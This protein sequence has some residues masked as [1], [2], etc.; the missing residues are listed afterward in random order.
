MEVIYTKVCGSQIAIFLL[1]ITI[2]Q[3]YSRWF[4]HK[5][6]LLVYLGMQVH[7]HNCVFIA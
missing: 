1:F 3:K 4:W 5:S 7:D 6:Y 2:T